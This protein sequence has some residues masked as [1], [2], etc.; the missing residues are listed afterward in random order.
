MKPLLAI[1]LGNPLM[2]DEGI[3]WHVAAW[4]AE[5]PRLPADLEVI[6][7]GTDLLRL[8]GQMEGRRRVVVIDAMQD[9]SEPGT[10][11]VFEDLS[12]LEDRQASAHHLSAVQA[13][14]LLNLAVGAR[15]TLL[16]IT[17]SSASAGLTL[18]DPLEEKAPEIL[19]WVVQQLQAQAAIL[20]AQDEP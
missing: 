5:D 16:A 15:F 18:S 19:D 17:I 8:Q 12:G 20:E 10:V 14:R 9:D 6:Q 11:T 1:G 3:G 4:L 2:G 7:G 13:M